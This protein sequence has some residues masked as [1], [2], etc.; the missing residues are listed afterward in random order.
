MLCF[1]F[2]SLPLCRTQLRLVQQRIGYCPQFDAILNRLTG[3]E[4]LTMFARLR[5]IPERKIKSAVQTEID[6]LDLGKYANKR[7]GT[8]RLGKPCFSKNSG[9]ICIVQLLG[10]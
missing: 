10:N 3:R 7:C 5:G 8:Y 6:R 2:C 4:L 9:K 1:F